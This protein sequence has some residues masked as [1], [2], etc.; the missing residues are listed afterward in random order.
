MLWS[1]AI[2]SPAEV[3]SPGAFPVPRL[4][5]LLGDS[6]S[7]AVYRVSRVLSPNASV[8]LPW[9]R[10]ESLPT[11]S[12]PSLD[13]YPSPAMLFLQLRGLRC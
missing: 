4:P 5:P 10:R 11:H 2:V 13:G 9:H 7:L 3:G 12:F 8:L 6:S 1:K